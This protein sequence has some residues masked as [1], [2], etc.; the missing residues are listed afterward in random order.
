MRAWAITRMIILMLDSVHHGL[1]LRMLCCKLRDRTSKTPGVRLYC[2]IHKYHSSIGKAQPEVPQKLLVCWDPADKGHGLV[3]SP[4]VAGRTG[5]CAHMRFDCRVNPI[6]QL[7]IALILFFGSCWFVLWIYLI[8][9]SK[10]N[11]LRSSY[12]DFKLG[13][14]AMRIQARLL[15]QALPTKSIIVPQHH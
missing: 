13:N 1:L 12:T 3:P 9:R 2:E 10:A 11:L 5:D 7:M 8:Y 6:T 14:L 4:S 15:L